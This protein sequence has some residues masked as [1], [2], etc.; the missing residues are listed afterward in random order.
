[1]RIA[2]LAAAIWIALA[3]LAGAEP[4]IALVVGNGAYT[5][6]QA[7]DN[8]R[9]DARLIA[10][11]LEG[12]G[13]EVT[14]L[15]DA[16]L[17]EFRAAVASFGRDLRAGGEDATGLF[18]YAGHALQSFQMNYLLPVDAT[19]T[20]AADIDLVGIPADAVLRQMS[21]A[22]NRTNIVIFD[23]CRNNP[24]E[25]I[26]A[27]DNAGLAEMKAPTGTFLAYATAPNMVALDGDGVNS[28]FTQALAAAMPTPGLPVEQMFKQVRVSVL[29][30]TGGGQTPWDASSLTT[31][32]Q[33]SPATPQSAEDQLWENVK[34]SRDPA[35]IMLY[36]RAYPEGVH[37]E[38]AR[39]LLAEVIATIAGQSPGDQPVS[40]QGASAEIDPLEQA[41]FTIA[42]SDGSVAAW[43]EFL[44][45][46][47]DGIFREAAESELA[48]A[49][50]ARGVD[51]DAPPAEESGPFD[52]DVFFDQPLQAGGEGVEGKS[53][54]ELVEKGSP[55]FPPF[56][57]VP[58]QMWKGQ[59]CANCHE[60]TR[61]A[62]CD[63]GNFY[64]KNGIGAGV[65]PVH[66]LGTGFRRALMTWAGQDC[67]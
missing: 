55:L 36:M 66:P 67:R 39:A 29:E 2:A 26:R 25:A 62:L 59:H 64:V 63:Q 15:L 60:W 47:P 52:F 11:T 30:A 56:D 34:A 24:F 4:R 7:L 65:G 48:A 22:R 23:A 44:R 21:S 20:D 53:I 57:G 33:F 49:R 19:L 17:P 16:P 45:R 32:F 42:R 13:F 51:P 18:Y 27:F 31:D 50:A 35:Q 46:H 8:P 43:E 3:T 54:A 58:E 14:L 5:G 38:E 10:A 1:M 9:N 6:V 40:G 41:D 28:P 37:F 12:L 61:P